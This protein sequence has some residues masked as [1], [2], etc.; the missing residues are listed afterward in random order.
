MSDTATLDNQLN[1]DILAGKALEA[2]EANYA[3][4]VVM[5]ENSDE[6]RRGKEANREVEMQFFSSVEEFHGA[7]LLASAVN[8]DVTFSQW[9][10]DL[11][12]KGAPRVQMNQV[13][14][15]HWKDGKV[16][17]ERFYYTK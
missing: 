4:D 2:F 5:Q 15:R 10:W 6:P 14:V 3:D 1:Q 12:F 13:A 8:G 16:S 7:K 17:S 11:T 9:E